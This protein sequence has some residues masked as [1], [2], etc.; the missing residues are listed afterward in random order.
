ML[1]FLTIASLAMALA[2]CSHGDRT[3]IGTYQQTRDSAATVAA[4]KAAPS[5]K[6]GPL[7]VLRVDVLQEPELTI[8]RLPVDPDGN[9]QLPM[10]GRLHVADQT[11]AQVTAQVTDRLRPFLRRPQVAVNLVEVVSPQI[12]V[13]GE[14]RQSGSFPA[15]RPITL[16]R[17]IALGQGMTEYAK[18]Q[19]VY[20]FRTIDGKDY[21]ARYDLGAINKG[22]AADPIVQQGDVVVVGTSEA[23]HR[24]RDALVVLPVVFGLFFALLN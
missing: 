11:V 1:R 2:A 23:R 4:E 15:P 10:A 8:E 16:T 21:A 19:E 9:I 7:D 20:I 17:A 12:T 14:V 22:Q 6:V 3:P 5:Y 18:L 13:E 24:F